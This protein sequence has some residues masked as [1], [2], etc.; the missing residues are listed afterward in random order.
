MTTKNDTKFNETL[1]LKC[2]KIIQRLID[3]QKNETIFFFKNLRVNNSFSVCYVFFIIFLNKRTK[4]VEKDIVE[5]E[6][7]T[8]L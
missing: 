8:L 7:L 4:I 2:Q 1:S 3:Y 5:E 6:V